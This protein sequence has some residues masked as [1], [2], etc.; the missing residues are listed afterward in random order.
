MKNPV[1]PLF[2]LLALLGWYYSGMNPSFVAG[3]VL[4][5]FVRDGILVLALIVPIRAG[6][7][8]NFAVT[9][10]AMATQSALLFVLDWQIKGFLGLLL[11]GVLGC[12]LAALLGVVI[13]H[14][15]NRVR[16]QEMIATIIIGFV[17]TSLYQLCFL[18]G[19]GRWWPANNEEI[20]LS[21]GVGVRNMVDLAEYRDILANFGSVRAF[22]VDIPL[23]MMAVVG[24][25]ALLLYLLDRTRIGARFRAVGASWEH[26]VLM[27]L[28]ADRIRIKAMV[29]SMIIAALGQL[30]FLENIGMLNVYTA[31]FNSD[32]FSCAALL[33]GG[34]TIKQVKVRH[35]LFG[36]IFFHSL[37]I[38][39]PQAGQ[40]IFQNAA[41]GEYFRSFVAYGTI[42]FALTMNMRQSMHRQEMAKNLRP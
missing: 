7:G 11:V 31:H 34:A 33:A 39:S 2:V 9:I 27:G 19:Y 36:I 5:R 25:V 38:V 28:D 6:L 1:P 42:A 30:V 41:L 26:S 17:G 10:G 40:N 15:L 21:R 35:A 37:F 4:T 22:G 3:E 8:L 16:G 23:G 29:L 24:M 12:G 13:G 32:I 14:V 18:A 20:V